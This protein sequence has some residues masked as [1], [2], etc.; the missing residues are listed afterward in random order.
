N[1]AGTYQRVGK[2][3]QAEEI[4]AKGLDVLRRKPGVNHPA[5]S[6]SL[7]AFAYLQADLG[8]YSTAEK[9]Y[10]E[11]GKLMREQLGEQ[12]P[13]YATF[14]NNRA[15]LYM[16]V[17]NVTTAESDYRKS[18][19]LKKAIYGPDAPSVGATLRNLARLVYT[20]N[21]EEG[22]KLFQDA[23][24]LYAKNPKPPPFDYAVAL[25]GVAEAQRNRRELGAARETLRQAS[26]VVAKGL[27][28]KHPLYA[29]VLSDLGLDHQAAGE[30]VEARQRLQEA[31]GIVKE[32]HGENHPDLAQY[33]QRLAG[34]D[35]ES[36]D[37]GAAALLYRSSFEISDNALTD[38]LSIGS[39]TNKSAVLAN[40]E[41][42]IPILLSFQPRAP[43]RF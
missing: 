28:R 32:T 10:D 36:G 40:L 29:A 1:L 8:H 6:A 41:D 11:S 16:A 25:L 3:A 27:G 2:Y 7:V 35:D 23:A 19:D 4:F 20:R 24:D 18:L 30:Y 31:I 21:P 15:A 26:E 5:Y 9:L 34:V 12:H 37:Y 17:G 13:Y 42:P 33:V 22:A 39:E 38:M 14:L 43:D